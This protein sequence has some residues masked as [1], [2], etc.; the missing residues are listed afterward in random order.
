MI[1]QIK[2]P[3]MK[4]R[5]AINVWTSR[6]TYGDKNFAALI[7]NWHTSIVCSNK[8]STTSAVFGNFLEMTLFHHALNRDTT[9]KTI[10]STI[11]RI[12]ESTVKTTLVAVRDNLGGSPDCCRN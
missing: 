7:R 6:A 2:L 10:A 11:A 8:A 9:A 3:P 4:S 1:P 12:H 5:V